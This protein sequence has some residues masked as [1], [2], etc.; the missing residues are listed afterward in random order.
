MVKMFYET[1]L[2]YMRETTKREL[3]RAREWNARVRDTYA[4][5]D[6]IEMDP[7]HRMVLQ[8]ALKFELTASAERMDDVEGNANDGKKWEPDEIEWL[9]AAVLE[10]GKCKDWKDCMEFTDF[11]S[12]NMLRSGRT[13]TKKLKQIGLG[14]YV[15]RWS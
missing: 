13:I 9:K 6:S 12:A 11:L 3:H 4:A 8:R 15:S 1:A 10:H 14:D 5:L 7:I 2:G